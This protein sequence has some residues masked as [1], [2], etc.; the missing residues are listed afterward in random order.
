MAWFLFLVYVAIFWANATSIPLFARYFLGG[1]F[2]FGLLYTIFGYDVYIGEVFITVCVI[3]L[4]ALLCIK[5]KKTTARS[6]V[7]LVIIFTAGISVCF[8][9][10]IIGGSSS[11]MTLEPAFVPDGNAL[12]Q[13]IR[14]AFLSPWAFIGFESIS[15]SAGEYNFKYKRMFRIL[16]VSLIVITALYVFAI[17]LSASAY[18]RSLPAPPRIISPRITASCS[19]ART[20]IISTEAATR[21]CSRTSLLQR[22]GNVRTIPTNR[23]RAGNR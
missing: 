12:R 3:A 18:R 23:S 7:A 19:Q 15:H 21:G 10:A 5:S 11:G 2:R 16:L 4:V 1:I 9:G 14:I 8:I 17:L 20:S 22:K 6:M 13:V